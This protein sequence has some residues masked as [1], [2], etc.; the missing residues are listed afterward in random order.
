MNT[1][2]L[3]QESPLTQDSHKRYS[4]SPRTLRPYQNEAVNNVLQTW[5]DTKP[6]ERNN[7]I[8]VLPTGTGKSTVIAKLATIA[9]HL[10]MR[11]LLLAHRRELLDQMADSVQ[12]VEPNGETVG[13]VQGER[14]NPE[15]LIVAASFQTL[16]ANPA[17]FMELGARQ[18]VLCDEMHHSAAETYKAILQ[19]LGVLDGER[20]GEQVFA[21]GFTATASREDG[22]LGD[23]W[24]TVA[25]EKTLK[26]AIENNFLV[27]PTGL[28]VVLPGL[29]LDNITIR[30]GDYAADELN[31][32]MEASADTTVQAVQTHAPTRRMIVFA[33]G[34]G[35]CEQLAAKLTEAGIPA[36]PITG[37]TPPDERAT[38]YG[39]FRSGEAQALVTVQVLTEGAD[40]PMCDC[41]VMARPTRSQTLYSQMVGRALR[42]HP[43]KTDALVLD[44]AGTTRDMSLVTITSLDASTP[45][46][47]VSPTSEEDPGQEETTR[48]VRPQRIGTTQLEHI[49]LL[50][51]HT[52]NWLAT[53]KGVTFLDAGN[54]ILMLWPPNP[55]PD[56]P[57]T[58]GIKHL[59]PNP[60]NGWYETFPTLHEAMTVAEELAHQLGDFPARNAS[61][62]RRGEP[63]QKQIML[64]KHLRIPDA[65]KKTRAR[66]ADDITVAKVSAIIDPHI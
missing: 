1:T 15:T 44:L 48:R 10:G 7:P 56:H 4:D 18:V 39:R 24:D 36:E 64:A 2:G 33:S 6:G 3:S 26:W 29:N 49:N 38:K 59:T 66:L 12:A 11:V 45:T 60:Q 32:V 16:V 40:F 31:I 58:I 51:T 37:A 5:G 17:R 55:Q 42:L 62:R 63:S 57:T 19:D 23:I 46:R 30:R 65:E 43:G 22:G 21:C 61:W 52:G 50:D 34:V 28:T 8:V 25:Y 9:R 35:H 13:I 27:P 53:R 54:L 47:R 41:V 20:D 14:H